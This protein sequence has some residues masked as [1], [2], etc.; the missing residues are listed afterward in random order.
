MVPKGRGIEFGIL[1][2]SGVALMKD[3]IVC[4]VDA[5]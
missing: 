4:C 1:L 5:L 3:G 2:E